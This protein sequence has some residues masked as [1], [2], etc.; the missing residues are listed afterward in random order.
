M[1]HHGREGMVTRAGDRC[2]HSA[3]SGNTEQWILVL[4]L[5]SPLY[6]AWA[7]SSC[8]FRV[9]LP[10]WIKPVWTIS[11]NMPAFVSMVAEPLGSSC[12]KLQFLSGTSLFSAS[13]AASHSYCL[14]WSTP[15][16]MSSLLQFLKQGSPS[17]PFPKVFSI[18]RCHM[19]TNNMELQRLK[20]KTI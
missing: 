19:K 17:I 15:G 11:T 5:P 2:S 18:R 12:Q 7:P 1:V 4:S 20:E 13:S 9:G 16:A 6:S 3:Q 8:L 10:N 14:E